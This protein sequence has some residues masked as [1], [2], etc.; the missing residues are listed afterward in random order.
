MPLSNSALASGEASALLASAKSRVPASITLWP[1]R[2]LRV[3]GLG[4]CSVRIS[5]AA[6]WPYD[7]N[8]SRTQ[9]RRAG[10]DPAG[11]ADADRKADKHYPP[12]AGPHRL[13]SRVERGTPGDHRLGELLAAEPIVDDCGNV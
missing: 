5:M 11:G 8:Q 9:G 4:V 12:F 13:R 1:G 2:N 7:A 6:M 3:A 10:D